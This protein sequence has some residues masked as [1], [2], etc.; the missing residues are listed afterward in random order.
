V[1]AR[2]TRAQLRR[3]VAR[4]GRAFT[5]DGIRLK[6]RRR[7]TFFGLRVAGSTPSTRLR[8]RYRATKVKGKNV[9]LTSQ[10]TQSRRRQVEQVRGRS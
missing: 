6:G 10:V 3:V 4:P 2:V 9:A 8:V 5:F 1:K 7:G